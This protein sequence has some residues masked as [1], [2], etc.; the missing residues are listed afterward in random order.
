MKKIEN[1]RNI[2]HGYTIIE[3]VVVMG[4]IAS[5]GA[6]IIGSVIVAKHAAI[7]S[8]NRANARTVQNALR[9]YYDKYHY[10]CPIDDPATPTVDFPC[11][12]GKGSWI[13]YKISDMEN[14]LIALGLISQNDLKSGS[15]PDG[16]G[17]VLLNYERNCYEVDTFNWE[18]YENIREIHEC[19]D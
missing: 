8:A 1:K 10:Y 5:L 17:E 2:P 11:D 18:G 16:G 3:L 14:T 12:D 19:D 9:I 13:K 15:T 4:I 7:E 6:L